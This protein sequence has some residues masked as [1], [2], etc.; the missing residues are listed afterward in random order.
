MPADPQALKQKYED[1]QRQL[2]SKQGELRRLREEQ[3]EAEAALKELGVSSLDGAE[4]EITRLNEEQTHLTDEME[5][6]LQEAA[7]VLEGRT[8]ES[9]KVGDGGTTEDE[10]L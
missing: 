1:L 4:A 6:L 9:T 10:D 5:R 8:R 3:A 7:D 2:A